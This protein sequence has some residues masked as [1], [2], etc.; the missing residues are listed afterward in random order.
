MNFLGI[1]NQGPNS[2]FLFSN[3]H[4]QASSVLQ[5]GHYIVDLVLGLSEGKVKGWVMSRKLCLPKTESNA[6]RC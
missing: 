5:I 2:S 1:I 3:F 4:F 6:V